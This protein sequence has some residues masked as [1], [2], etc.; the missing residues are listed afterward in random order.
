MVILFWGLSILCLFISGWKYQNPTKNIFKQIWQKIRLI[1]RQTY[2]EMALILFL[3]VLGLALRMY[4]LVNLPRVFHGD[5]GEIGIIAR[6][7]LTGSKPV[8]PFSVSWLSMPNISFYTRAISLAIFGDSVFGIRML[9][10]LLGTLSIPIIYFV[11]K[12]FWGKISGF[13]AAWLLTVSHFQIQYSRIGVN[14]I[15]SFFFIV[16]FL[17]CMSLLWKR[18]SGTAEKKLKKKM[19]LKIIFSS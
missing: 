5:E 9:S 14:N 7:I 17:L 13:F 3:T 1:S 6:Y 2:I 10:V 18:V 11:G 19:I 16:L 15:K 4:D 12:N 8:P